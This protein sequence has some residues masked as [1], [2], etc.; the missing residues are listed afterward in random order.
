MTIYN[1]ITQTI[2]SNLFPQGDLL[3]KRQA[4]SILP[5][6]AASGASTSN[7]DSLVTPFKL[8]MLSPTRMHFPISSPTLKAHEKCFFDPNLGLKIAVIEGAKEVIIAFGPAGSGNT[9]LAPDQRNR[10]YNT[11]RNTALF[12]IIGFQYDVYERAAQFVEEFSKL[13]AFRN[14]KIV[15]V[16]QSFGGSLAQYAGLKTQFKTYCF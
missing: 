3:S 9:E 16:G 4:R 12:N 8:N 2:N 13:E 15:I 7:D 11:Q 10:V 1:Y 5:Y 6:A 14:K